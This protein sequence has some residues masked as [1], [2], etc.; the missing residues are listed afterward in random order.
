MKKLRN[1]IA[2]TAALTDVSL[3]SQAAS[4]ISFKNFVDLFKALWR[5]SILKRKMRIPIHYRSDSESNI[6]PD[7]K[8]AIDNSYSQPRSISGKKWPFL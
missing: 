2:K 5:K 4:Q 1:L 3:V 8:V 6:S 7:S